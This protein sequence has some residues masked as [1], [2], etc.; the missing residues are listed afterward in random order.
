MRGG[1]GASFSRAPCEETVDVR[2]LVE[3]PVREV[4]AILRLVPIEEAAPCVLVVARLVRVPNE[5]APAMELGLDG[6]FDA[7]VEVL[8]RELAVPEGGL[9]NEGMGAR[10]CAV[11]DREDLMV[12]LP[13]PEA[14]A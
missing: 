7:A 9:A 6:I 12:S 1:G 10:V 13:F 8:M 14:A 5:D 11:E 2:V 3:L 4:A